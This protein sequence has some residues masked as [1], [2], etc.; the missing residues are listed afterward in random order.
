MA[1]TDKTKRTMEI[2]LVSKALA[3][4][5]EALISSPAAPSEELSRNLRNAVADDQAHAELVAALENGTASL[6]KRSGDALSI[7]LASK[8][9]AQELFSF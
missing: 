7:A 2:A 1:V 8:E 6:E 9:A 3:D 5:M 4:E